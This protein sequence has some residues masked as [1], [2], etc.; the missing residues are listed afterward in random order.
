[1]STDSASSRF[2]HLEKGRRFFLFDLLIS[3][4]LFLGIAFDLSLSVFLSLSVSVD[5]CSVCVGNRVCWE[6]ATTHRAYMTARGI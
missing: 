2:G 4:L 5:L 1:M 6:T 3:I